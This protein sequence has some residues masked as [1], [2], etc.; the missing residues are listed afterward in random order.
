MA[1]SYLHFNRA[2]IAISVIGREVLV[3]AQV[4]A[5]VA[6]AARRQHVA[7][8]TIVLASTTVNDRRSVA[9]VITHALHAAARATTESAGPAHSSTRARRAWRWQFTF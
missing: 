3:V 2:G 9:V 4:A 1:L 8:A 6:L 5:E 7:L